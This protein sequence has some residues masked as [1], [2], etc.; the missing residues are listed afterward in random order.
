[1][2]LGHWDFPYKLLNTAI[3]SF[4]FF[5]NVAVQ[6]KI[7]LDKGLGDYNA[8]SAMEEGINIYKPLFDKIAAIEQKINLNKQKIEQIEI[9]D[10]QGLKGTSNQKMIDIG[11]INSYFGQY[12]LE[13]ICK[14]LKLRIKAL[15]FS[16]IEVFNNFC[17]IDQETN[18]IESNIRVISYR[19]LEKKVLVPINL[20]NKHCAGMVFERLGIVKYIDPANVPINLSLEV[21][22]RDNGFHVKQLFLE[23]QKYA[24]CGPEVIENFIHYLTGER[25]SQ[26]GAIPAHSMLL[27]QALL[28]NDCYDG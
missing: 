16:N 2:P 15:N 23:E 11:W 17:F 7:I 3:K 12:T 28:G 10:A 27:E 18:N 4:T 14:I 5:L 1:M 9:S 26:E 22:I 21:I 25:L 19:L 8:F 6:Y 20:Y 24:N 13:S